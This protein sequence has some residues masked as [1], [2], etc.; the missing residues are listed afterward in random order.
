MRR[1]APRRAEAVQQADDGGSRSSVLLG[2]ADCLLLAANHVGAGLFCAGLGVVLGAATIGP[3]DVAIV[4]P[5]AGG[6][7]AVV[8]VLAHLAK[9]A[10]HRQQQSK[11]RTH[12]AK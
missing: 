8:L 6:A 9:R 7:M 11:P 12:T 2:L 3:L 10:V 1:L 5:C 4:L